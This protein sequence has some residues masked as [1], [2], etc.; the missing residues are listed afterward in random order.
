MQTRRAY[1]SGLALAAALPMVAA[2]QEPLAAIDWLQQAE[3]V[4]MV[5]RETAGSE[6]PVTDSAVVPQVTVT[7]LG[8]ASRGAVG[9]LPSS[10]TGFPRGLWRAS[11]PED[12]ARQLG[13]LDVERSPA[14]QALLYTLLLAEAETPATD[15]SD[16][17]LRARIAKLIELGAVEP[18]RALL[19]RG[20]HDTPELFALW[21]DLSLLTGQTDQMCAEAL[22]QPGLTPGYGLRI[23]CLA[24]NG[25]W[26]VAATTLDTARLLDELPA[27]QVNLLE[28]FLD[29][30][31]DPELASAPPSSPDPLS[32]RLLESVGEAP[33][34]SS[35][36]RA[37]SV[38][39]LSGHAGWKA[40]L[41]AAE[42][43][44]RTGAIAPNLLLGIFTE[45]LPA[46]SGGIWDRVEALQRIDIAMTAGDPPAIARGL[47]RGWPL[48]RD[49]RLGAALAALYGDRLTGLPLTGEDAE[50]AREITLLSEKYETA[51]RAFG[52][53]D[54]AFDRFLVA[55]AEGRPQEVRALDGEQRAIAAAFA[56]AVPPDAVQE[57]IDAGQL[58][59]AILTAIEIWS[60]AEDGSL[61][62][63][64]DALASFRAV[65]LEDT[66][67][68]AA[69]QLLLLRSEA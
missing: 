58:G 46:A 15:T 34:T 56:D 29:P 39:D 32:Y 65:G 16:V 45:R 44:A 11:A 31:M 55:L 20:G 1:L 59:A 14:M 10:V 22:A 12:L 21:A 3:P 19:E 66:A 36:P 61:I 37:F 9:L 2:A 8:E 53:A 26:P 24:Q 42:R 69:L 60:D 25:E 40:K 41:E 43:L 18:A 27:G 62:A 35:L 30:D 38:I 52:P 13:A 64:T 50:L 4:A 17:L 47:A 68:R 67:R 48:L 23:Y 57:H 28:R 7:E 33:P 63:L 51:V 49:A 6:P 54:T 5:P